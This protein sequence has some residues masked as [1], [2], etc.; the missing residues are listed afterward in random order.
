MAEFVFLYRSTQE[1]SR[2][3]FSS[4]ERAQQSIAKWRAWM[5]DLGD[6]GHLKNAGEPLERGGKVVGGT[7][8]TVTDGP[9]SETKDVIGGFSIIQAKDLDQAA[10]LA[11]GCPIIEAGGSVEVRPV[12]QLN[13]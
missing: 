13:I 3:A 12:M 1:A 4:P 7:K 6:K 5:K 9:Y 2:E 10:Q 8:K 11:F